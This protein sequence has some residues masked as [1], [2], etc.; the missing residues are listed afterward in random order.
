MMKKI[1][2]S[3]VATLALF[4]L[5]GCGGENSSINKTESLSFSTKKIN[6]TQ[7][8]KSF[9]TTVSSTV[10]E[11]KC[12]TVTKNYSDNKAGVIDADRLSS[13]IADWKSNNPNCDGRLIIIQ[14]GPTSSGKFLKH[15]DEDVVVYQIPA[16]GSCDPSYNRHD[17]VANIPGA[18]L[19]GKYVDGMISTFNMDPAKD[20]V[21]FA[22]G[23]GSTSMREIVRSWWVLTYWGW[24]EDRL[25]I[26]NGSIDYNFSASSGL[27]D[28]LVAN[29]SMPPVKMK[30]GQPVIQNKQMIPIA[31]FYSMKSLNNVKTDLQIYIKDMMCIAGKDDKSG[32][33]IADTRGT[34]EYSAVK[35]SR[36]ADM[37]CGP[38]LDEQ[39]LSPIQGHI[40]DAVDFP[41]TDLLVR[42]DQKEDVN[43]DGKIDKKDASYKFKTYAEL[44]KIYK[45]KGYKKGD[46][47][48]TYCRTGRKATVMALT[49]YSVLKYPVVMY[50]GSW[51]QWGEMANRID[52]TGSE[53]LDKDSPIRTDIAKYTNVIKYIDPEYTQSGAVYEIN[54][55]ATDSQEI[56]REDKAYMKK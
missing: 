11:E 39:C 8:K 50:D 52:V 43:N 30:D 48:V 27:S 44:E 15:N 2:G 3:F 13:Y 10:V 19:S 51:I 12:N 45:D 18:L 46:K 6:N 24:P 41:Y 40:R 38:N 32:Y 28:F 1:T 53:I 42:D 54:E 35:S 22:V 25:A 33:F 56:V 16:G 49:S 5:T 4:T 9:N 21:V 37:N 23:K 17:G 14:A 29:P 55:C 36:T 34:K 31:P 47:I 26:L 7:D 20:F